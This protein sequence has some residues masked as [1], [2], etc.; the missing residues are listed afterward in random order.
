MMLYAV[1]AVVVLFLIFAIGGLVLS[2]WTARH[3]LKRGWERTSPW[4]K[5]AMSSGFLL[6]VAV[7]I[8]E[9]DEGFSGPLAPVVSVLGSIGDAMFLLGM[10]A[11]LEQCFREGRADSDADADRTERSNSV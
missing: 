10:L 5:H 2:I 11:L 4:N 6:L 9:A 3:S 7:A 8:L 1:L